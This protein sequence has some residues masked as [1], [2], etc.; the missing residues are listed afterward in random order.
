[1][2]F[3]WPTQSASLAIQQQGGGK[4]WITVQSRAALPLMQPL[5]SGFRITRSVRPVEAKDAGAPV[6]VFRHAGHGRVN[7][8]YRR[9]D[10]N[11]GWIDPPAP[12]E[13]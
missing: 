3:R 4:P 12:A 1:M 11:V 7:L 8:V 10:G 2:S 9:A 5:S 6:V 13:S